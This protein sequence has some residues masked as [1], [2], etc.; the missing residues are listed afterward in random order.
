ML[1]RDQKRKILNS[2]PLFEYKIS[3]DRYNNKYKNKVIARELSHT[4]NCYIF[5]EEINDHLKKYEIDNRGWINI[6][7]MNGKEL[8]TLIELVI[9]I[10]NG[11]S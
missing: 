4:G 6:K 2:Y 3:Y 11:K 9:G 1:S 8:R 7:D 5:G 10:R